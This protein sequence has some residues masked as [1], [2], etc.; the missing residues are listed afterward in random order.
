M[1]AALY[2][3]FST[4]KQSGLS[5]QDQERLCKARAEA[6][7]MEV[8]ATY[9]DGATSGSMP[10]AFRGGA[11]AMEQD[12]LSGS[13]DVILSESLSRLFRDSVDQERTIRRLEFNGVR[14]IGI[15]DG[16]DSQMR[17]RKMLRG[18]HGIQ[19]EA[20]IDQIREQTHRGLTG[21]ALKGHHTGG[22]SYGYRSVEDGTGRRLEIDPEQAKVVVQIYHWYAVE[23]WSVERIAYR[24]NETRVSSPRGSVWAKS[25]IYGCP[26][27]GAGILNNPLYDGRVI[28]NRAQW[29]KN[30]DTGQ[31]TRFERP[32]SERIEQDRPELRIV[33]PELWAATRARMDGTRAGNIYKHHSPTLF[34]GL[35]VCP[36]CKG[37]VNAVNARSYGC[38]AAKESGPSVCLGVTVSRERLDERL[39]D[40]VR[41]ELLSPEAIREFEIAHKEIS[42]TANKEMALAKQGVARRSDELR[43]EIDN[44]VQALATVGFSTALSTR[45]KEAE[46]ELE[47]LASV[48]AAQGVA[49]TI[50]KEEIRQ[51]VANLADALKSNVTVAKSLLQDLLGPVTIHTN[52][53]GTF[54]EFT[55]P[56]AQMLA[57]IGGDRYLPVVAGAGFEPQRRK[58][59][60]L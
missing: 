3:R 21:K 36:H 28:W 7:G 5:I 42:S 33:T 32:V 40:V 44:V 52:N 38:R 8:V 16:Y 11:A 51:I 12:A 24:L 37:P 49:K 20:Y 22:K 4:S 56:R 43:R 25:G 60:I 29:I 53:E 14:I 18:V 34:G 23:M 1:K 41:Q 58:I 50:T 57:A 30:P 6:M 35:L 55:E 45:L 47:K 17:S 26:N 46:A 54:A 13:F 9:S 48:K 27:K 15:N 59:R 2:S 31:R 10:V 39:L 19:N